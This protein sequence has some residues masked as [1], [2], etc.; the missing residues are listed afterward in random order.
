[1]E[2]QPQ[3]PDMLPKGSSPMR[4]EHFLENRKTAKI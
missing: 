4:I 3:N 1:M 2:S